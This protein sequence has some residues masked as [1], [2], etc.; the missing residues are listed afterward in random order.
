MIL[1]T[2]GLGYIGKNIAYHLLLKG[3]QIFLIDNFS[4]CSV[5]SLSKLRDL[6][7]K[8]GINKNNLQFCKVDVSN[9][10]DFERWFNIDFPY[11]KGVYNMSNIK[12]II[13]CAGYKSVSESITNPYEYYKNNIYSTLNV[14][15]L[16]MFL[17]E[18]NNKVPIIFSSSITVYGNVETTI[19]DNLKCDLQSIQSPYG[20]TKF[21]IEEILKD[22][23][24]QIP[25]ICLRYFNPI[26][27]YEGLHEEI[28]S[29]TTNIIPSLIKSI[30]N[31]EEFHIF[32]N[33]Y[34][35]RDGTCIRDYIDVRDLAEAHY[36]SLNYA[37][38][39]NFDVINLGSKTG[40]TVK[41]LIDKFEKVKDIKIK[42]KIVDRREGDCA[43]STCESKKAY[44]LLGWKTEY[45]LE[46]SLSSFPLN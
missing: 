19:N 1:I 44:D 24:Y 13:H 22:V 17:N 31:N 8:N 5:K 38:K 20:K 40:T 11:Y 6:V 23:S 34:N 4:N 14:I 39:T 28:T 43:L 37:L 46:E 33:D 42:Y 10:Q 36:L 15:K 3:E 26:G 16:A 7:D 27:C 18:G 35:T 25:S 32:G 29:K 2:G 45:T 21:M 9:D 12:A 41:E 30:S